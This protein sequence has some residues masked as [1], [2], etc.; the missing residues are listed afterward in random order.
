MIG[1]TKA[2][3]GVAGLIKATLALHHRVLPPTI[4]VTTPN[5]R[6]D[7]AE[8]PFYVNTETRPWLHGAD[9]HP[10][11]AGVSAF[12]FGGTNFHA[13]LEE[14]TGEYLA[15]HKPTLDPWPAELFLCR[16]DSRAE[17]LEAVG[18]LAGELRGGAEPALADLAYT[19]AAEAGT[20]R[21]AA[22]RSRSSPTRSR[23]SRRSCDAAPALLG[24]AETR[25]SARRVPLLASARSPSDGKVAFLFPGQGSQYVNMGRE[26]AVA[27]PEV[28]EQF[29]R[30][31]RVARRPAEQPLSRYVFPPPAFDAERREA[32]RGEPDRHAVAQ[33][34][35]GATDLGCLHLLRSLGVEP[36]LV[37]G[38]SYGEFVA[39]AAAG[40]LS[41]DDLLLLS[42][43]RGRF[44]REEAGEEPGTMAA[45]DAAPE[46][47]DG[48]LAE[49]D[50]VIANL[51][52]PQQTVVSGSRAA[53]EAAVAWCTE[54]DVRA[55]RLPVACAFHS[56]LVAPAQR[57]LAEMLRETQLASPR[58]P[59]YSN[60]TA[61]PYPGRSGGD[62]GDP[63]RAPDPAGRVLARG[64]GDV[65]RRRA[66]LRRGRPAQRPDRPRRP[67][68]RRAPAPRDPRRPAGPRRASH[69]FSTAL[70]RWPRKAWPFSPSG[71]S[72]VGRRPARPRRA[73]AGRRPSARPAGTVARRRRQRE[74]RERHGAASTFGQ[75]T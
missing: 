11:R 28:R 36:E 74:T 20:A 12:G 61:G 18:A 38:H 73:R 22:R 60:T 49:V 32:P 6:A 57:R 42:E 23:T 34:A 14:Y 51:N 27:F 53:I 4:G 19:L 37:A 29:E 3:A 68:P 7:F 58:I 25:A 21:R 16:G 56:P 1:H 41:E 2:T 71:C 46:A 33:P 35:L 50:V 44:I 48:L 67:D 69:S 30:S 15:N 66:D 70:P 52:A 62:R 24:S 59:V 17:V 8:S 75:A 47:L 40:S 31:D 55:R 65:R 39:L 72:T 9:D 54:R 13:V 26:L 10:R 63:R 64:R 45:I 43:A 5:P